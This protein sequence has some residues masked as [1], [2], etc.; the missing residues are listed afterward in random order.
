MI[1]SSKAKAVP[2]IRFIYSEDYD[3]QFKSKL[4]KENMKS[5]YPSQ[6]VIKDYIEIV[7]PLWQKVSNK[8]LTSMANKLGLKWQTKSINCNVVGFAIPYSEPLTIPIYKEYPNFFIDM[9][10]HELIHQI[11]MQNEDKLSK[12][13]KYIDEKYKDEIP[14]VRS[15]I[16]VLALHTILYKEII[17]KDRLHI[18]RDQFND[19]EDYKRAW[20]I[21]DKEGE[22]NIVARIKNSL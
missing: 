18:N 11:L 7:K 21:V 3:S 12:Y 16:P 6:K 15:H 17:G 8:L 20:D 19:L 2:S 9:V 5:D 4:E 14:N 13:W 22:E 10:T 1:D